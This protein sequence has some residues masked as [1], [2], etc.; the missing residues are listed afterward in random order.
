MST[1][2]ASRSAPD[3]AWSGVLIPI[4]PDRGTGDYSESRRSR[5]TELRNDVLCDALAYIWL[6]RIG[7]QILKWQN[8]YRS[9]IRSL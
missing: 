3:L 1:Y 5:A 7:V 2:P 9:D 8:S 6:Q 4:A